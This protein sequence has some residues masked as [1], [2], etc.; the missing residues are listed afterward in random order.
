MQNKGKKNT[1]PLNFLAYAEEAMSLGKDIRLTLRQ[2]AFDL[3]LKH[4]VCLAA[5]M[6]CDSTK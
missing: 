2:S 5:L 1:Y 6:S 3:N 4:I